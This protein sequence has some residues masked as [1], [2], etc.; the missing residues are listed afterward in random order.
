MTDKFCVMNEVSQE[1]R[2][3]PSGFPYFIGSIN[4]NMQTLER[5]TLRVLRHYKVEMT[6]G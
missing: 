3:D 2:P 6:L 5:K 1:S 4:K